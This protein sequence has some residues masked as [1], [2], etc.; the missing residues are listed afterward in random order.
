MLLCPKSPVPKPDCVVLVVEPNKGCA[1]VPKG[2]ACVEPK[3]LAFWVDVPKPNVLVLLVGAPK[4]INNRKFEAVKFEDILSANFE[5][6]TVSIMFILKITL[7]LFYFILRASY[8][9]ILIQKV[10]IDMY[11]TFRATRINES[12]IHKI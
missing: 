5:I 10:E 7:G 12:N 11:V 9:T 8:I 1:L 6:S 3:G 4:A 2:L